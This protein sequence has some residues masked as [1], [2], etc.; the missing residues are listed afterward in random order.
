MPLDPHTEI[1]LGGDPLARQREQLQNTQWLRMY[2]EAIR[3]V[4]GHEQGQLML[5]CLFDRGFAWA[6]T[7]HENPM[8]AAQQQGRRQLILEVKSIGALDAGELTALE[9]RLKRGLT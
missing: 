6:D 1:G 8:I 3:H 4:M 7:F 5:A 2:R 9:N